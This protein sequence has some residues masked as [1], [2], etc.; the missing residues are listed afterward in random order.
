M[1]GFW[2]ICWRMSISGARPR[3][4]DRYDF[5]LDCLTD[6]ALEDAVATLTAFTVESVALAVAACP[7]RPRPG[8]SA[9]V[10]TIPC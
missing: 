9:A 10:A 8:L 7:S 3:S 2:P 6:L 4:L 1:G 5:S